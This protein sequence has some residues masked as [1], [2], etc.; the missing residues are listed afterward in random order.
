MI[1][2]EELI[3][4][5]EAARLAG[6]SRQRINELASSGRLGR[7]IARR[8]WVFTREEV[9][10]YKALPKSKGGRPKEDPEMTME[11]RTPA[12]AGAY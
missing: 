11:Y 5:G 8:Y 9:E 1:E 2:Q 6:I 7:Q 12:L 4:A 3:T 10:A